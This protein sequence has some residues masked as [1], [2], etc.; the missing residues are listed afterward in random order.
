MHRFRAL[1]VG[2]AS[3]RE[4]D[5]I[6]SGYVPAPSDDRSGHGLTPSG[7]RHSEDGHLVHLGMAAQHLFHFHRIDVFAASY[8]HVLNAVGH[9]EVA[10]RIEM[11]AIAGA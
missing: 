2:Q 7:A 3:P 9:I 1:I 10:V 6:R 8:D 4:G 5:E 11:P